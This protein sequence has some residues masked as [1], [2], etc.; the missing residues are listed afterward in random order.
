[1][2]FPMVFSMRKILI[3]QAL[4]A[5][6]QKTPTELYEEAPRPSA[7]CGQGIAWKSS[8]WSKDFCDI[9]FMGKSWKT[10]EVNE[11]NAVSLAAQWWA[12]VDE[13]LNSPSITGD[14][15]FGVNRLGGFLS[16]TSSFVYLKLFN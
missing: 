15:R 4:L 6:G 2:V 14:S 11:D 7:T 13:W 16:R 1:M 3:R 10:I 5:Q 12:R 8:A 9:F